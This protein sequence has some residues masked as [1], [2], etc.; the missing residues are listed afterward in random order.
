M[1]KRVAVELDIHTLFSRFLAPAIGCGKAHEK[2]QAKS[3]ALRLS[4][5]LSIVEVSQSEGVLR[6]AG[7]TADESW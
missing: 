5:M 6:E 2:G 7:F 4:G 3:M 1:M